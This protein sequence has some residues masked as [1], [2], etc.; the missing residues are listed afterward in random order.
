MFLGHEPLPSMITKNDID[1]D[2][3]LTMYTGEIEAARK[4]IFT[5]IYK[6][7]YRTN[8]LAFFDRRDLIRSR[9]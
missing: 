4:F 6:G 8:I 3:Q 5:D 7:L 1:T 9:R 2:F